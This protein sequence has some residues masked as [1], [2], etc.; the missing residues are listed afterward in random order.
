MQVRILALTTDGVNPETL[1]DKVADG[2]ERR[3]YFLTKQQEQ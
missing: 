1:K 2:S 3:A